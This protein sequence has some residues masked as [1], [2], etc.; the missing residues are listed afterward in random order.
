MIL[1][2][3]YIKKICSSICNLSN[4]YVLCHN[5]ISPFSQLIIIF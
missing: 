4:H 3:I 1:I 2:N 5:F